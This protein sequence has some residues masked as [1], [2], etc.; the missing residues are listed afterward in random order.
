MKIA[1]IINDL[2]IRGGT[3]KQVLRLCQ[4]LKDQEIDFG[5]YTKYYDSEATYPEF[6]E[7]HIVSL[8]E[9]PTIYSGGGNIIERYRRSRLK[10][11]E[12]RELMDLIPKDVDVYNFHDNGMMWMMKWAKK[13]RNA[14]V[15]W[16]INDLPVCY[17]VW[18]SDS[19]R[20]SIPNKISRKVYKSILPCV[21]KI[22]VNV[23]KNQERVAE[24]MGRES[25]VF[26]CGVDINPN[27]IPHHYKTWF[28]F[29]WS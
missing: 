9:K 11:K 29:P 23:T 1:I 3:H 21:D 22:T 15:V 13:E 18:L 4:Y 7:F 14:K 16:Q 28:F 2:C 27:L 6:K 12:D 8:K 10:K 19:Y 17:R 5:L 26:Y 20:R 25:E 24:L